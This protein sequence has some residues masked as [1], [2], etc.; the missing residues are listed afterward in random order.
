MAAVKPTQLEMIMAHPTFEHARDLAHQIMRAALVAVDPA[1]AVHNAL[2]LDDERLHIGDMTYNL[3]RYRRILVVGAGKASAPMARAVEEV[4]GDRI[5]DGLVNVK[6]GYTD[7]TQRIRLHEA[8]HPLPDQSGLEGTRQIVELLANAGEDDLIVCLISGGGSALMM[9][10]EESISLADYQELTNLMLRSGATINKINTVRKHIER[11][12]G[13]RL[14]QAAAPAAVATLILSDVVG[15]PLDFIA[16]G[17]TVPDTT[18]FADAIAVLEEFDLLNSV[19]VSVRQWLEQGQRGKVPETPKPGD[20][21]FERVST[22]VIGSNDI[23]AEAAL[24]E[25]R[26]LGFSAMLLTTFLEGEARDAGKFAAAL[27]KELVHRGNPVATPACLILGGETTVTVKGSGKGGRNQEIAL[28]AAIAVRDLERIL[29]AALATDGTDGPTDAAGGIVDGRTL[30]R[31]EADGL[32][33]RAALSNNDSNAFLR[34]VG[35]LLVTGPTNTNVND[36][37]F[38]FAFPA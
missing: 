8:G 2:R 22:V 33:A 20:P 1:Q 12:K 35:D 16:S 4:L 32:D 10:P 30:V 28:S 6:Y 5:T 38:V 7:R 36:L 18:T 19:P 15:N 37:L 17:P 24:A 26:R 27:A 29:I 25:A 9:L 21:L 34:D 14:A 3:S 23:A 13:G 11:V 31:A